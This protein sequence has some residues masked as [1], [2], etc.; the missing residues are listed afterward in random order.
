MMIEERYERAQALMRGAYDVKRLAL[1]TNLT[2]HWIGDSDCF[3]YEQET[4]TGKHFRLV[5]PSKKTNNSAFDHQALAAALT[6]G[7]GQSVEAEDLPIADIEFDLTGN[8]VTFSAFDS[9]WQY[10][11]S[12]KSCQKVDVPPANVDGKLSPDGKNIAFVRD[13]NLWVRDVATGDERALTQDGS[14]LYVYG[15]VVTL[16][17]GF[18]MGGQLQDYLWSPDSTRLLARVADTR[19]VGLG[20]PLVQHVPS[21]GSKRPTIHRPDRR[22]SCAGDKDEEA[23]RWEL[24]AI[25]VSSGT[26]KLFDHEPCPV[27]YPHY[28]GFFAA[29]RGWWDADSRHAYFIYHDA[30]GKN[31]QLLKWDTQSGEFDVFLA[32]APEFEATVIPA[33]YF[34]TLSMP[35]LESHEL[36]WYSERSGWAHLYLYD[37]DTGELKNSITQ[38]DWLVR[39]ILHFDTSRRE[40][41]IQTAGRI[42]GRNP[43]YRDICRV[44]IDTGKLTPIVSTDHEYFS[45]SV[46]DFC[47]EEKTSI[48]SPSGRYV[49][50]RRSRVDDVP[51]ALLLN[52]EGQE[53]L[54]I[55]TADVSGLPEGWQWPEPVILKGADDKTDIYGIVF[56]PSDFSPDKSYPVLDMSGLF[57]D[58]IG[59]FDNNFT[60]SSP[61]LSAQA[62]AELG[63]IVVKFNHRGEGLRRGAGLRN[64]AFFEYED[65]TLPYHNIADCV[66]G[67]KQLCER[68]SYMDINR[69]GIVDYSSIPAAITGLL[70]YPDFYKVG[71]SCNSGEGICLFPKNL[72]RGGDFP[73]LETFAEKLQGKLL[74]MAG[75]LDDVVPVSATFRMVEV[76]KEANKSFDML[77][78]PN[79]DHTGAEADCYMMRRRWDYLVEHL[80]NDTPPENFKL[81]SEPTANSEASK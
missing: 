72:L 70:V 55:E 52:R 38:G 23:E 51:V 74:L 65:K 28:L 31:L 8:T 57:S 25:D 73:S 62:H 66:A 18:P 60:G 71:V 33:L 59:S 53:L 37:T 68:H 78:L 69:V 12:E 67:I 10:S 21:D 20:M 42:K 19:K 32:E 49:V 13:Y 75:M 36:I 64:R 48:V 43:Y 14:A 76:L 24:L 77:L 63:F 39:D 35:L 79:G 26:V 40:L 17:G 50:A 61:Y 56:R 22:V 47:I 9:R 1:N 29:N 81:S 3:W 54:T 15:S 41:I 80:L 46:V 30:K 11:G 2:P 44:N 58:P 16:G 27:L 45:F 5:D 6:T 34:A 7:S 4:K